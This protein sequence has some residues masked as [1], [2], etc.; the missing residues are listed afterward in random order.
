MTSFAVA[1]TVSPVVKSSKKAATA[2]KS[3]TKDTCYWTHKGN[4]G[5][6]MAQSAYVNWSAGGQNALNLLGTFNYEANYL[7]D[8][9]KWDNS[10]NTAL[11][12]S[13]YSFKFNQ[14][15]P[16]KTDDR[17]ELTSLAGYRITETLSASLELAFRTQYCKGYDYTKDSTNY[18][19]KFLAPAYLTLGLGLE[20]KPN[21][22]FSLNFAPL[23]GRL[24]IVNDSLLAAQGAF[25][26]NAIDPNDTIIHSTKKVNFE[27][28]AR[29]T[30]KLKYTIVKNVDFESKLELFS[31]YLP[32]QYGH[33]E[34]SVWIDEGKH[35]RPWLIDVDWQNMLVFK[36]NDWLNC[37]LA[38]HLIYDY[39]IP[40]YGDPADQTTLIKGSKVQFKEV[41]AVGLMFNLK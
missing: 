17:I 18:I 38:T 22:H 9:W 8:K 15:K 25:G 37:N 40:F 30:A 41:F 3:A 26:V 35:S 11:G 20:W 39:D 5:F 19:S 1:Q 24:V 23:T 16:I 27:F 14:H 4:V 2:I 6:N 13:F 32:R 29:L 10:F 21:E 7:K 28:G 33:Y 36:V 12:Y 34:N 31:N